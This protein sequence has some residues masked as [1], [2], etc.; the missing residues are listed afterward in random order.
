M[1]SGSGANRSNKLL[2]AQITPGLARAKLTQSGARIPR[3]TRSVPPTARRQAAAAKT[4]YHNNIAYPIVGGSDATTN[5]ISKTAATMY[6]SGGIALLRRDPHGVAMRIGR[7]L[8]DASFDFRAEMGDQ[9]LDRPGGGV[10]ER[11]DRMALD[12]GG[13]VEQHVDLFFCALPS[14]MRVITR[15]I[16]PVPSR[17]GVHCPQLSCL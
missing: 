12:L 8:I 14:A 15:H 16:Q 9:T 10:A 6:E 11:A 2:A 13:D 4:Q 7:V 5:P 3:P 17:H 1:W